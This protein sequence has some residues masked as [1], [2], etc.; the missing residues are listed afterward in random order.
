MTCNT[1]SSSVFHSALADASL[2]VRNGS[3]RMMVLPKRISQPALPSHFSCTRWSSADVELD[4]GSAAQRGLPNKIDATRK[5]ENIIVI[6]FSSVAIQNPELSRFGN[7]VW[8]D[9]VQDHVM[10]RNMTTK[11]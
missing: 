3:M 1:A 9:A 8:N 5:I 6:V 7:I 10:R 4:S 2:R 11:T